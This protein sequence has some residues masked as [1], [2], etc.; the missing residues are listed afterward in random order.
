M[1]ITGADTS[2]SLIVLIIFKLIGGLG[3]GAAATVSPMYIAEMA[4]LHGVDRSE[5][6]FSFSLC[7]LGKF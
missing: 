5:E 3:V 6:L 4:P 2:S 7:F 1:P